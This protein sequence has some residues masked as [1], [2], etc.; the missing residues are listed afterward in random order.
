MTLVV[1]G[2]GGL[3]LVAVAGVAVYA[4]VND[5]AAAALD[6][7]DSDAT[8]TDT[9]ATDAGSAPDP[10]PERPTKEESTIGR[11][12]GKMIATVPKP[13]FGI[14]ATLFKRMATKSIQNYYKTI[15]GADAIAINAKAGQRLDLEPVAYRPPDECGDDE[16]PG[17][18]A[19]DRDKVWSPASE[20]NSVNFL[21]GKTPTV[22]LEDDDHV[23]AGFLAPRIGEAIEL[24]RYS[25][26]FTNAT[27][28]VTL[29][30]KAGGA[31]ADGGMGGDIDLSL[32]SPGEWAGD[33]VVDLNS[34]E[35]YS[36]MRISTEKAREWRAEHAD[37]EAMKRAEDRGRLMEALG[38]EDVD[39]VRLFIYAA[40]FALAV[41]AVVL[42]GPKLVGSGGGSGINP[43]TITPL[44]GL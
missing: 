40:L 35:G 1:V 9:D 21:G 37:S 44:L 41:I 15:G 24:D 32:N 8:D 18:Y 33:N 34:G 27:F 14:R 23:E 31:R 10:V 7:G 38:G 13:M 17:W 2:I 20:G 11:W 26:L 12:A 39:V 22:L 29:S 43:L 4:S 36:G 42:L 5:P 3:L 6:E 30:P 16:A 25:P 19:K 28:D